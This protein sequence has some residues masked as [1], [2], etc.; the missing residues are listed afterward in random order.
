M[1]HSL[2][3]VYHHSRS[4]TGR[5]PA[6][7]AAYQ[8][9]SAVFDLAIASIYAYGAFM[10]HKDAT[11][12]ST[13]LNDKEL[14][15]YLVPAC[16]YTVI[17]T[18]ALHIV[19]M[20]VSL[21]LGRTFQRIAQMPPDMNPLEDNLTA[22]PSWHKRNKSA[23]STSTTDDEKRLSTPHSSHYRSGLSYES[24]PSP[25]TIPFMHTRTGSRGTLASR[26][27]QQL[28]LPQRQ[29]Q[30]AASNSPRNSAASGL[31]SRMS[32]PRTSARDSGY[33][34]ISLKDVNSSRGE[35]VS[36]HAAA[37]D[38][39]P[40]FTETW[41][42]TDSLISRTNQRNREMAASETGRMARSSQSYSAIGQRYNA[43]DSDSDYEDDEP[44]TAHDNNENH[45]NPL[46]SHPPAVTEA[47]RSDQYRPYRPWTASKLSANSALSEISHN[48]RSVPES[49][50]LADRSLW[51]NKPD[52]APPGKLNPDNFYSRA[53]GDLRS[54]TPPVLIGNNNRKISSGNDYSRPAQGGVERRRVSGKVAE[55]GLAGGRFTI[56]Y[57]R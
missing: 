8:V 18:G 10:T 48:G 37:R 15:Q 30:I 49:K 46:R 28:N 14:L 53:Y 12:W 9:F 36:N 19:S 41:M 7:T 43:D 51:E 26:D 20:L 55:E 24:I 21:W 13:R 25:N 17:G 56:G 44:S 6:S 23:V 54:A 16:Y 31:S 40:K 50:D 32:V 2:Y 27:S 34:E 35:L 11:N 4:A 33:S 38:R 1:V 5:P 42:P 52:L 47:P 29:Y 22:R 45:P 57:A 3:G 39:A